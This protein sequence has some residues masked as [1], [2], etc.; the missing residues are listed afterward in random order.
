MIRSATASSGRARSN[1]RPAGAGRSVQRDLRGAAPSRLERPPQRSKCQPEPHG[2]VNEA[3]LSWPPRPDSGRFRACISSESRR[4]PCAT[5]SSKPPAAG[6]RTSAAAA[7]HGDLRRNPGSSR[8]R[9]PARS[10][11]HWM[12]RSTISL[13]PAPR[14][15]LMIES[16]YF[17]GLDVSETASL[18][19]VSE[20]TILRDWRAAKAW[21]ATHIVRTRATGELRPM[22]QRTM[23]TH[24]VAVSSSRRPSGGR[25]TPPSDE[26]VPR[27]RWTPSAT[28]WP[29]SHTT[30]VPRRC[31]IA[32]S[33][34]PPATCWEWRAGR[35][36]RADI[37]PY[38]LTRVLG[39]G[40]MAVVYLATSTR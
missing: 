17:G 31:W 25:A 29:C 24:S 27:R 34:R 23:G 7:W 20:A 6:T 21:L 26:R 14:Q 35:S 9:R 19:D 39:E 11:W 12:P 36:G 18:L 30:R 16:R 38:W 15:A 3:W 33:L 32:R 8:R 22:G 1:H 13:E 2:L 28:C 5:S 4:A 40:G 10:C 37:R